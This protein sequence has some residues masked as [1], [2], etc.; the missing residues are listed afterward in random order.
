MHDMRPSVLWTVYG[1][2]YQINHYNTTVY[3]VLTD[4][5]TLLALYVSGVSCVPSTQRLPQLATVPHTEFSVS[6]IM[7]NHR[8]FLSDHIRIQLRLSNGQSNCTWLHCQSNCNPDLQA[9]SHSLTCTPVVQVPIIM[10]VGR[11]EV[12]SIPN[13]VDQSA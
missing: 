13:K 5:C 2:F 11:H 3:W 7:C 9:Q 12:Q 8:Q 6:A 4:R 10:Q 1:V